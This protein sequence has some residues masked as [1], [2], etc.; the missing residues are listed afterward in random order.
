[1]KKIIAVVVTYNPN[2]NQLILNLKKIGKEVE[3]IIICNNSI[4]NLEFNEKN[5]EILNFGKN[6]GI[7]RAQNIGMEKAFREGGDYVIQFDQDSTMNEGMIY[8]LVQ[9]YET[10]LR[11]GKKEG[12]IG[13]LEY[14]RDTFEKEKVKKR[15][16]VIKGIYEV[17]E[18]ISS[19]TLISKKIYKENGKLLEEWFIDLVDFEYCWRIKKAGYKIYKD[20]TVG[21]AHKIGQG[22]IKSKLGIK[23]QLWTPFRQYYEFRNRL[24]S[25][26]ISYTPLIWKVKTVFVLLGKYIIYPLILKDGKERKKFMNQGIKDFILNKTGELKLK[27]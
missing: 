27:E 26:R 14:D 18:I 4:Y 6:L 17:D 24:Y 11:K 25:L 19:G 22:K 12:I 20:T 21:L 23:I 16:E 8:K 1:M 15:K 7:A 5:I 13:P 10:L 9:N 2:M 3:K